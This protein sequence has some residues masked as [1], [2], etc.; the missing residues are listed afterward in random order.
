MTS[1]SI[2]KIIRK[3]LTESVTIKAAKVTKVFPVVTDEAKLP[4]IA[5]RRADIEPGPFK[6]GN[7]DTVTVEVACFTKD[8]E[9]GIE[10]AE[11]VREVLDCQEKEIDGLKMRS[12]TLSGGDERYQDDAYVQYL[13]F[14]IKA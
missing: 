12:C 14:T 11:I 5:Y 8:Y 3:L 13:I 7:A 2:G 4:Y 9:S 10:L 1:L 6:G